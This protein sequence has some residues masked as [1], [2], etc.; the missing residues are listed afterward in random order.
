MLVVVGLLAAFA[1][2]LLMPSSPRRRLSAVTGGAE[3][4]AVADAMVRTAYLTVLRRFGL[5]P[6]SR[7]HRD[8]E[9]QHAITAIVALAAE[10]RAGQPPSIALV[11]AAG[12]PAVWPTALAVLR[13]GGDVSDA[14][15]TDAAFHPVLRSL[16]ACWEVGATSG[17]G[18]AAA[19]DRLAE[20]SRIAADIR[21]QLEVQMAGPRSTARVL[22]TLPLIGLAMGMLLG[23]D[24][25]AWLLGSPIGLGCLICGLALTA[26]G[27][28]WTSRIAARVEAQL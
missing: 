24:P 22:G 6:G 11:N 16:A 28:F 4:D 14:L 12:T 3:Q 8:Q 20:S 25:L 18:L 26:L 10:L 7:R 5:G 21:G 23:A 9:R 15:R 13:L 2:A 17:S 27:M 1:V 19:V